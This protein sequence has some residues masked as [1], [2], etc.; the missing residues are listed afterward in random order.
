MYSRVKL[1]DYFQVNDLQ[2]TLLCSEGLFLLKF[3]TGISRNWPGYDNLCH[4]SVSN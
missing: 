3:P 2:T 4:E 1:S